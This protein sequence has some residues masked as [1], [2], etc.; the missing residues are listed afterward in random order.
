MSVTY[1][2]GRGLVLACE[3]GIGRV[4]MGVRVENGAEAGN[5]YGMKSRM[6]KGE[7]RGRERD[8]ERRLTL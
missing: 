1:E 5:G 4:G 8:K 6:G 3:V 2:K 7:E